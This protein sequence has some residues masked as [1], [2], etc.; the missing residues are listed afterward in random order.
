[1]SDDKKTKIEPGTHKVKVRNW[2]LRE[3]ASGSIQAYIGFSNGATMFQ[4]V[5]VNDTGDEILASAL[6]LCG[7]KGKDLPDLFEDDALDKDR[8]VEIFIKYTP[9][10]ETGE[11]QMQVYVNDPGKQMKGALDK[12]GAMAKLKE[13]KVSLKKEL[14]TAQSEIDLPKVENKKEDT[15]MN[16]PVNNTDDEDDIPF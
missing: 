3:T 5:N 13:M 4:M 2:G 1:M 6:T 7:F 8:E 16:E 15:K 11:P 10:K 12:K 9:H 14:K